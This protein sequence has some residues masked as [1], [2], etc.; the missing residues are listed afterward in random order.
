MG[1]IAILHTA[2]GSA[3]SRLGRAFNV[4]LYFGKPIRVQCLRGV[5][6]SFVEKKAILLMKNSY[7]ALSHS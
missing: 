6:W 2:P 7:G 5:Q 4:M 1:G 3:S